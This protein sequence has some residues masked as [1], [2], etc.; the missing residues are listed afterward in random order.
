MKTK[1]LKLDVND[2]VDQVM[3]LTESKAFVHAKVDHQKGQIDALCDKLDKAIQLQ[4][5]AI[6]FIY[7]EPGGLY[8]KWEA[9]KHKMLGE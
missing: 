8:H 1:G 6:D 4:Q 3:E 2:L 7:E 9:Y 5:C